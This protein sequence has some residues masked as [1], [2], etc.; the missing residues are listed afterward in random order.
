MT[1]ETI[2]QY[3]ASQ[4]E[5]HQAAPIDMPDKVEV[6][7]W[8]DC[9]DATEIRTIAHAA[10]EY[11][12]HVVLV[13]RRRFEFLDLEMAEHLVHYFRHVCDQKEWLAWDIEVVWN[14]AHLFLGLKP[15]DAPGDVALA[16]LNNSAWTLHQRY[17]AAIR[18]ERMSG[19]WQPSYYVGTAGS[20]T[21]AQIK[22]YLVR[23]CGEVN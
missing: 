23:Q 15:T 1:N 3:I 19:I 10:F 21:T 12:V 22:S 5:H 18:Y 13:T 14:H 9:C 4:Y 6:A 2:R 8:H 17:G 20:A 11:N 16:L 7:R